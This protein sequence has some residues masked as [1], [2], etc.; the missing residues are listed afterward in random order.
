MQKRRGRLTQV[1]CAVGLRLTEVV[2][3]SVM[4]LSGWLHLQNPML[5]AIHTAQ[6]RVLPTALLPSFVLVTPW[7]LLFAGMLIVTRSGVPVG[8]LVGAIMFALFAFGQLWV[9]LRGAD[10]ECGCFGAMFEEKIGVATI[11]RAIV[12]CG[13]CVLLARV[14]A[15]HGNADRRDTS[16]SEPVV[17]GHCVE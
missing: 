7:I 6:Y 10:V 1:W 9:V 14:S 8:S 5:F 2:I 17:E 11:A 16:T 13:G 15:D 12:L 3:G 4:V